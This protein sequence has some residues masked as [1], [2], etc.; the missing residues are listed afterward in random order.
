MDRRYKRNLFTVAVAGVLCLLSTSIVS[1]QTATDLDC[2][3]CVGKGEVANNTVGWFN[4]DGPARAFLINQAN[5]VNGFDARLAAASPAIQVRVDGATVGSLIT[6]S[7]PFVEVNLTSGGT[8]LIQE[9]GSGWSGSSLV[10]LSPME[11]AFRIS[12]STTSNPPNSVEGEIRRVALLFDQI[13]CNG[14]RYSAVEGNTGK[15]SNFV[16]GDGIL[17]P[18]ARWVARQG[19]VFASTDS[20]NTTQMYFVRKNA[21]VTT[22]TLQSFQFINPTTQTGMCLNFSQ[23][24][25]PWNLDPLLADHT[26]VPVEVNDPVVTG[27]NGILGGDISIGF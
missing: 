1:A 9:A 22:V 4:L 24:V 17:R 15:F 10:V 16:E 8:A 20:T 11:Y 12:G 6:L 14:N 13:D 19:F 23:P 21:V 2:T 18:I 26:V 3:W 25:P 7:P 27:V 5:T